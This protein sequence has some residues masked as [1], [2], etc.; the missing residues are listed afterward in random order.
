MTFSDIS[1]EGMSTQ[2]RRVGPLKMEIFVV[3]ISC[4]I[5][6]YTHLLYQVVSK[7]FAST[8]FLFSQ[9]E[10]KNKGIMAFAELLR[11]SYIRDFRLLI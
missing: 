8:I 4:D 5:G 6:R 1:E 2:S 9:I 3:I 11:P 10:M 7:Y